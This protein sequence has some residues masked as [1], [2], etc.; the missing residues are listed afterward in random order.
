MKARN[1]I[2]SELYAEIK[3]MVRVHFKEIEPSEGANEIA[4]KLLRMEEKRLQGLYEKDELKKYI[5]G[6]IRNQRNDSKSDFNRHL[7]VREGLRNA[8]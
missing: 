7:R 2:I 6:L 1:A 3:G 5:Y 4:E 8:E